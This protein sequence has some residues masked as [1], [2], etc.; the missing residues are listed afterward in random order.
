MLTISRSLPFSA[1]FP[2]GGH[3]LRQWVRASGALYG[4]KWLDHI[5]Y[6]TQDSEELHHGRAALIIKAIDGVQTN[7]VIVQRF[8]PA[9]ARSGCVLT[10]FCCS[11]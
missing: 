6:S 9:T 10:N 2:W 5:V 1:T 3:S 7:T 8:S 4:G 11:R